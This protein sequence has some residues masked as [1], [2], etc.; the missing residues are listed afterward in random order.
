MIDSPVGPAGGMAA[1]ASSFS[2]YGAF[3]G[4]GAAAA[5]SAARSKDRGYDFAGVVKWVAERADVILLF[6]DPAKPGTTG[7]TLNIMM[8]SLA[9]LD[10]KTSIVLNK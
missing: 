10:F 2:S 8:T 9:G 5:A 4:G 1:A 6:Q 3:G 7:E